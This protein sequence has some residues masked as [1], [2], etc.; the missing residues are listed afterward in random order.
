MDDKRLKIIGAN[1]EKLLD[2]YIKQIRSVLEYAAVVWHPGLTAI[3]CLNIERV[4]KACLA[5]ILGKSYISYTNALQLTTL[6]S[7][8]N[9]RESLCLK[10]ARS[11]IKNPKFKHWFEEDVKIIETRRLKKN[12]KDVQTR[13]KRFRESTIPYLTQLLN[14]KG[15]A[16]EPENTDI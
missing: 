9:R 6:E 12:L 4:Q 3:N 13:T 1:Q 8:E 7:L 16:T 5:I 2:V 11:T 15:F 14:M 10:F